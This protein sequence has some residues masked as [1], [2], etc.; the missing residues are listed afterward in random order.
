MDTLGVEEARR[1]LP[2]LLTKAQ[3]GEHT[4]I[5]RHDR[6]VAALVPVDQRPA[7]QRRNVLTLQGSGKSFWQAPPSAS[8][9]EEHTS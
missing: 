3:A 7:A 5:R 2:E 6:L 8:R 1:R 4:I 9:S